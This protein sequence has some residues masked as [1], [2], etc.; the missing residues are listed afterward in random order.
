MRCEGAAEHYAMAGEMADK[1]FAIDMG[2][3]ARGQLGPVL[4]RRSRLVFF[5]TLVPHA[6][7]VAQHHGRCP[8]L[9][10]ELSP[11]FVG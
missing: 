7:G 3:T 11:V 8:L 1:W 4:I 5:P 10:S 6:T 9:G 2:V